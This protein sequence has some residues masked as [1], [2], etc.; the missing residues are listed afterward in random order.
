MLDTTQHTSEQTV[1]CLEL[2]KQYNVHV[3]GGSDFRRERVK[4]DIGLSQNELDVD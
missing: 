2:A 4:L 3:I 1:P